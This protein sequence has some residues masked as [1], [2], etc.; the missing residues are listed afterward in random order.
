MMQALLLMSAAVAA[1]ASVPPIRNEAPT[2]VTVVRTGCFWQ[3]PEYAVT[4]R[5][6]GRVGYRG[7]RHVDIP[8]ARSWTIPA[9]DVAPLMALALDPGLWAAKSRYL[10]DV[11]D[12]ETIMVRVDSGGQRKQI[13]LYP[14]DHSD[15]PA[16]VRK[17]AQDMTKHSGVDRW[18]RISPATLQSLQREGFDFASPAGRD[19]LVRSIRYQG[20]LDSAA[21][22]QLL[23]LGASAETPA[24]SSGATVLDIVLRRRLLPLAA[25]LIERGVL[26]TD[27]KPDQKKIDSAFR[28]AIASG[29]MESAKLVWRIAGTRP[30]PALDFADVGRGGTASRRRS[31]VVLLLEQDWGDDDWEGVEIARWLETLGNDLSA[32]SE[33]RRTLMH[34]AAEAHDPDLMKYLL[35]RHFD[36]AILGQKTLM[37]Y[38]VKHGEEMAL[39]LLDAQALRATGWELPTDY[40]KVAMLQDWRL[41]IAWLDA[42]PGMTYETPATVCGPRR[43]SGCRR[44]SG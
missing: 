7:L 15:A 32:V 10:E 31:P 6:D 16:A 29:R 33:D 23:D 41:V 20:N 17:L 18:V 36:P 4:V 11:H 2:R 30:H 44:P 8:G 35:E 43:Q 13:L 21:L 34:I 3:C 9:S 27:G 5:D 28:S 12:A 25:P 14:A 26:M 19:L 42:H 38:S 39:A 37:A 1:N 22:L 24:S 40:R